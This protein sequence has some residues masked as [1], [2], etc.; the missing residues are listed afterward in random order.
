MVANLAIISAVQAEDAPS[1]IWERH[2]G[3]VFYDDVSAVAADM[4]GNVI[5]AGSTSGSIGQPNAGSSDI[6]LIK[7]SPAGAVLW[8]RQKGSRATDRARDATTDPT[9]NIIVVGR[10][11]GWLFGSKAGDSDAFIFSYSADG[12]TRWK[13]QVGTSSSDSF[14]AVAADSVGNVVVGG[15]L[16]TDVVLITY[17]PDGSEK[18]R[19]VVATGRTWISGVALAPDGT[20]VVTGT[21]S[22]LF[23]PTGQDVFLAAY[24][25]EGD[26][27]W[28]KKFLVDGN[29]SGGGVAVASDGTILLTGTEHG[30][31]TNTRSF[32]AAYTPAGDQ[33]WR[34]TFGGGSGFGHRVAIDSKDNAVF[35]GQNSSRQFAAS[36][37]P[38]GVRR[39]TLWADLWLGR[40]LEY[41]AFDPADNL[42]VAGNTYND[43][44][45]Y[46]DGYVA[47][48]GD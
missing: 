14:D 35:T 29:D 2:P 36:F 37:T 12:T 11:Y 20:I 9:G 1:K 33:L 19:Q 39:W 30:A 47:K 3:T 26:P 31:A 23:G 32:Q 48:F 41:A 46:F 5:V 8:R 18:W 6:F 7:Y 28:F 40:V 16:G 34:Q 42:L 22:V 4:A 38:D 27:L 24:S 13:H 43:D 17:G 21:T 25:P 44:P 10:T 45:D 15:T